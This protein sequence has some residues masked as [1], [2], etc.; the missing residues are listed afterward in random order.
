MASLTVVA[1]FNFITLSCL[2]VFVVAY[3][4]SII[5]VFLYVRRR[6]VYNNR[7][8]VD[9]TLIDSNRCENMV[10]V[11]FSVS[12]KFKESRTRFK[13][14]VYY[15]LWNSVI[16]WTFT[17]KVCFFDTYIECYKMFRIVFSKMLTCSTT[18]LHLI[19][20]C[21]TIAQLRVTIIC[22]VTQ[23]N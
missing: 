3:P 4:Y 17:N 21:S 8:C 11:T 7:F 15:Q 9:A 6:L 14:S 13:Y 12:I 23:C 5:R 20:H 16:I 10:A 1:S 22:T 2:V 18:S 19:F